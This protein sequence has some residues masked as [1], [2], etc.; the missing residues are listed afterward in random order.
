[1]NGEDVQLDDC[2]C[3]DN[4]HNESTSLDDS[5]NNY[6]HHKGGKIV[7]YPIYNRPGLLN[8]QYRI[9][10]HSKF[11]ANMITSLAPKESLQKL[12]TRSNDDLAIALFDAWAII[13]DILTFY[14]ERMA[15]E[16]FLRT[17][18]RTNISFGTCTYYRISS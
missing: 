9:G 17:A 6:N 4:S 13:A 2:G 3:C 7:P 15:N 14:Q 8:L 5:D 16:G 11:R 1:M 12:T 18:E 10:T